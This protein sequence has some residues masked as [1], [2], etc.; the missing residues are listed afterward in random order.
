VA[1]FLS[2]VLASAL[3]AVELALSGTAALRVALPAMVGTHA[4]IGV[5]EA[6]VTTAALQVLL[7]VRPDLVAAWRGGPALQAVPEAG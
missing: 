2:I 1:A 4:V 7:R 5:G 3:C 6:A